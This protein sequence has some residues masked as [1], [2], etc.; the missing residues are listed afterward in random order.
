MSDPTKAVF[1]A[2]RLREFAV[3]V[4]ESFGVPRADAVLAA[5]ILVLADLRGI[6][7]HGLARLKMYHEQLS[8][9]RINPRPNITIVRE[10][11]ST[12]TV[13]GDAGLGLVVGPRANAIAMDKADQAGSGWGA[14]RNTNH[15]GIAGYYP[16]QA[17]QRDQIGLSM[18]NTTSVV[19]PLWGAVRRLGT[20]PPAIA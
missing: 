19:A 17:L 11:P 14:V 1:P 6:D 16:L 7:S 9:G 15:Y 3:R 20:T 18:T 10:S 12:A 5:D 8:I 13:D 4:F 2:D